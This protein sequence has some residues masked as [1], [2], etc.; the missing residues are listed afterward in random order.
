MLS[1]E[2]NHP[3]QRTRRFAVT[4]GFGW[5]VGVAALGADG[6]VDFD[7]VVVVFE[8]ETRV[9]A[10]AVVLAAVLCIDRECAWFVAVLSRSV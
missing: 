3:M 2:L 8:G 6:T 9:V 4:D 1:I 10:V 7:V 5:I